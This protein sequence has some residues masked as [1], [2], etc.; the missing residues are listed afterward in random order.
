MVGEVLSVIKSLAKDGMTMMIVTHEMKFA[1]DVSNRVFYMDEGGIYEDGTPDQIFGAPKKE[2]TRIFIKR[3]K[4]LTLE[5]TSLNFDFIGFTAQIEQ[6]GRNN[7]ISPKLLRGLELAFEELVM[8]NIRGSLE[9]SE[10]GLPINIEIEH[11]E[12]DETA[13]MKITYGGDR[14]DPFS[15]GDELSAMLIKKLAVETRYCYNDRNEVV[16]KFE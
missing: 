4:Q 16:I 3:L 11:S 15:D 10:S 6:F 12:T 13:Q 8:Q 2:K 9:H 1:R 5:I 7:M 14:Y